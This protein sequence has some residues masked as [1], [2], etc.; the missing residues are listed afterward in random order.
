MLVSLGQV[1]RRTSQSQARA[2]TIV[3]QLTFLHKLKGVGLNQHV[4][5]TVECFLFMQQTAICGGWHFIQFY[6]CAVLFSTVS[7]LH[8]HHATMFSL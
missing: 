2:C 3:S 5:H 4:L 7:Y 6:F 8:V 1:A